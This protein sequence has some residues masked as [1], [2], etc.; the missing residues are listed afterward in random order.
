M[1]ENREKPRGGPGIFLAA[2][3]TGLLLAGLCAFRIEA[4]GQARAVD[5]PGTAAEG[6]FLWKAESPGGV[7]MY[8]MGSLHM[9]KESLFPLKSPIME[10]FDASERLVVEL[11]PDGDRI[12]ESLN[13]Y[14]SKGMYPKGETLLRHLDPEVR[15]LIGPYVDWL[16]GGEKSPMRPWLAAVT[17]DVAALERLGYRSEFGVD[18]F[19]LKMAKSRN[20]EIRELETAAEQIGIFA[21]MKESEARLYLKVTLLDLGSVGENMETLTS[22]WS[23]GDVEA[24]SLAYFESLRE[25]PGLA[26]MFEKTIFERNEL[27]AERLVPFLADG[28]KTS[29]AVLG[30]GHLLGPRGVPALLEKR[31]HKVEKL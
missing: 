14:V 19:F 4:A 25:W 23:R 1:R 27:M 20:M 29:F 22:S 2:L 8:L 28:E 5:S 31:G 15:G 30:A 18:R 13:F 7:T 9:A 21:A 12:G 16:P 10:S 17:L 24:F 6:V 26:N 11:D 3:L